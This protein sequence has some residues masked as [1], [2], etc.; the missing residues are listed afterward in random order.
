MTD[1][2]STSLVKIVVSPMDDQINDQEEQLYM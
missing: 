2:F 1:D